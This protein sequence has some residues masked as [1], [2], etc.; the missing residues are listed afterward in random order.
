MTVYVVERI[1]D[2]ESKDVIA[3]TTSQKLADKAIQDDKNG[4]RRYPAE[5]YEVTEFLLTGAHLLNSPVEV[6]AEV[7]I[8]RNCQ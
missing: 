6:R 7:R 5:G 4:S 3:V 2:C 8:Q 1:N